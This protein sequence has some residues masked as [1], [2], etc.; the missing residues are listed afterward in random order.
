VSNDPHKDRVEALLALSEKQRAEHEAEFPVQRHKEIYI[1]TSE[2]VSVACAA[3]F[4][5]GGLGVDTKAFSEDMDFLLAHPKE[6][7]LITVGDEV[8]IYRNFKSLK[9]TLEQTLS[10][11]LQAQ[12]LLHWAECLAKNKQLLASC[13]GNHSTSRDEALLGESPIAQILSKYTTFFDGI[14]LLT[15][16]VGTGNDVQT[17]QLLMTH[18]ARNNSSMDRNWGAK[19]LYLDKYP[20]DAIVTSHFHSPSFQCDCHYSDARRLGAN[21]GGRRVLVACGTYKT[22]DSL[23]RRFYPSEGDYGVPTIMFWPG[24]EHH[25]EVFSSPQNAMIYLSG[26]RAINRQH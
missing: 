21:F 25:M 13:W 15:L 16:H 18:H 20:A 22:E 17:Y 11:Q 6:L 10:P 2:P 5:L 19:K 26:L 14:G 3:D 4:H 8:D 23:S 24:K 12:L 9:P 1:K 7:R